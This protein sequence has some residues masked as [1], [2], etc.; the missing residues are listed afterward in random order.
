MTYQDPYSTPEMEALREAPGASV[1]VDE[2]CTLSGGYA[3]VGPCESC[4]CPLEHAIEE[5]PNRKRNPG[6]C[7]TCGIPLVVILY[8]RP[9]AWGQSMI[10]AGE[11]LPGGCMEEEKSPTHGCPRCPYRVLD[12]ES[13][14]Y[15]TRMALYALL[16]HHR[17]E[18]K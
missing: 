18:G 17:N 9:D 5:C 16:Q 10:R 3:H 7:P 1:C 14:Q 12:P 8:G 6:N 11:R 4:G 13:P 15:K 2:D